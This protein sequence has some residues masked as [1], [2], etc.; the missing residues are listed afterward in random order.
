MGNIR[1]LRSWD[2]GNVSKCRPP[3]YI[4]SGKSRCLQILPHQQDDSKHDEQPQA[5]ARKYAHGKSK[6]DFQDDP[7]N[8]KSDQDEK[9]SY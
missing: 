8:D 4:E 7:T 9:G 5:A 6:N 3:V 1:L 2:F